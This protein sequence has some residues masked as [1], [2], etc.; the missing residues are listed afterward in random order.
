MKGSLIIMK[1]DFGIKL[2]EELIGG[3]STSKAA[4]EMELISED[5]YN[6][7]YDRV[8]GR[9]VFLIMLKRHQM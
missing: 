2:K 6:I 8:Q 7:F 1:C 4:L 9:V 3:L 5:K